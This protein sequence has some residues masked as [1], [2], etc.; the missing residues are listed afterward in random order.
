MTGTMDFS[1][2]PQDIF[3]SLCMDFLELEPCKGIDGKEYNYV[4]VIVCRLSGYILAVPCLKAGL[5][6]VSLAQIF[7]EKCV[8]FIGIPN[9]I[10]S[11]QD[12]LISSKFFST[13]CGLLGIEQHFS[14]IYR[15]KGNGRAEAAVRAIVQI[16][17]VSLAERGQTW[18]QALPWALFQQNSLPG[19]ILPFSP[20]EIVFGRE[21]PG[22]GDIPSC[23]PTRVSVSCE[24]WFQQVDV[25]RKEVQEKVTKTHDRIRSAFLKEH[26]SPT[27]EAGDKVWVRNSAKRTDSNKLDPLWT[28]PCEILERLGNSGR[29]KVSLPS[30]VEDMHMDQFKPYLTP[31]DGKAIPCH[32]FKPRPKLP[33]TD[34]LAV[35][36]IL[37]HKIEKGVHLWKVRWKG[38]GPEEDSWEPA[39]SFIGYIQQ[40]WKLWNKIHNVSVPVEEI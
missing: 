34:D 16:L 28:G 19:V 29:Y 36:K 37:D 5:T 8:S 18:L 1:P 30:G 13:L 26:S 7:L 2:I 27:Y 14:I 10:V 17:R 22:V 25:F 3:S 33:E 4:L 32:F 31:P 6:A 20:H 39:S 38:Y 12:H 35:Q 23:K 21:P 11:D 40:D 15:P 24:E 9:E